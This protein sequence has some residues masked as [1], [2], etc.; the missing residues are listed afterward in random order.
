MLRISKDGRNPGL[1]IKTLKADHACFRH[2]TIPSASAKFLATHFKSKIYHNPAFKVKDMMAEAEELLKITVSLQKCKRAKRMVIQ[3]MDGSYR[4]QFQQLEAYA[5]ALKTSNPGTLAEIQLCNESLKNGRRVFRRMFI[6]FHALKTGWL[7]GCR[8]I[9]GLDGC[10]LKGVCKGQ[11]LSA[12]GLDGDNQ[13]LPIVWA[14][15]DKENKNNWRWFLA[16]LHQE[17]ALGDGSHLTII[18]DMQKVLYFLC[19]FYLNI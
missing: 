8:P 19:Y 11:L 18:N 2:Y 16:W 7:A 5:H 1:S 13:L 10:F 12:V 9:I 6:C 14:I 17:L 15:V 4:I 3:E